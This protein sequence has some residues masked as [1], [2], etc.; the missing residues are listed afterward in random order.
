[1]YNHDDYYTIKS[2]IRNLLLLKMGHES[3]IDVTYYPDYSADDQFGTDEGWDIFFRII[4]E[5]FEITEWFFPY[6]ANDSEKQKINSEKEYWI[7]QYA[8]ASFDRN[9]YESLGVLVIMDDRIDQRKV[10]TGA[11]F[12]GSDFYQGFAEISSFDKGIVVWWDE[13]DGSIDTVELLY[14]ILSSIPAKE[15]EKNEMAV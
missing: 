11:C 12:G 1:M 15:A 5:Y 7:K 13:D 2:T 8:T 6:G 14:A 3:G 9:E 10:D 4:N